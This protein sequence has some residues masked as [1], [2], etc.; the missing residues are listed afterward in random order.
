MTTLLRKV[1]REA[2]HSFV[3]ANIQFVFSTGFLPIRL[4]PDPGSIVLMRVWQCANSVMPEHLS[5]PRCA[6]SVCQEL[7]QQ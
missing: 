2:T 6:S 5:N 4:C 3:M 1:H 7:Q